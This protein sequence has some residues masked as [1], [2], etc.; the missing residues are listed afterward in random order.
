[1]RRRWSAVSESFGFYAKGFD[2]AV[3]RNDAGGAAY[4]GIN[5][6]AVAVWLGEVDASRDFAGKAAA[7]AEGDGSYYGIATRAEAALI[8]GKEAEADLLYRQA[9]ETGEAGKRWADIASTRKQCRA[10]CLKLHSRRDRMDG[11][12]TRGAV[13]I[14]SCQAWEEDADMSDVKDRVAAWLCENGIRHAF[15]GAGAGW[16]NVFSEAAEGLGIEIHV[17]TTEEG[18]RPFADRMVAARG[19]CSRR[20]SACR[21]R[22]WPSATSPR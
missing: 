10:L 16:E 17:I 14:V 19:V 3:T 22:R 20:I 13:A 12:F 6:A 4:C 2:V 5:A 11:C 15:L 1:M 18:G 7:Y 9:S 8:L 21:S